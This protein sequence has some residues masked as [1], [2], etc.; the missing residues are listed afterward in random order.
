[1]ADAKAGRPH[2]VLVVIAAIVTI[3]EFTN[4]IFALRSDSVWTLEARGFG[5]NW[6]ERT[7]DPFSFYVILGLGAA[8]AA[9]MWFDLWRRWRNTRYDRRR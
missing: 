9:Y 5:I 7:A 1:M 2:A 6:T 4:V 8:L 3:L